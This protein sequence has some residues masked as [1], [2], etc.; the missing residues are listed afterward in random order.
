A[1]KIMMTKWG[2][3]DLSA[4]GPVRLGVYPGFQ[5]VQN[6]IQTIICAVDINKVLYTAGLFELRHIC[7]PFT[8]QI[9][10]A[11][12]AVVAEVK[13]VARIGFGE[14]TD[15]FAVVPIIK[16]YLRIRVVF[17]NHLQSAECFQRFDLIIY[18][19][20]GHE[21]KEGIIEIV[22]HFFD[23]TEINRTQLH[24]WRYQ[25]ITRMRVGMNCAQMM[26]LKIVEIPECLPDFISDFLAWLRFQ[27]LL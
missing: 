15:H 7:Y 12:K 25:K 11:E 27:K 16:F 17:L 10:F 26:L 22:R 5:V 4:E 13:E 24:V 6:G 3:E 2:C 23:T 14:K 20:I 19:V 21:R 9:E 8:M 18:N 1:F